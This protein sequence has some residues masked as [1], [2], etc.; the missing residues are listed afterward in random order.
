MRHQLL[1]L[2]DGLMIHSIHFSLI[3]ST[4]FHSVHFCP[5]NPFWT[6]W[7][8]MLIL[9]VGCLFSFGINIFFFLLIFGLKS[10]EFYS[11]RA[12]S[13]VLGKMIQIKQVLE[14]R[15]M[16]PK[17]AIKNKK[18]KYSK[19]YHKI[20]ISKI[21]VLYLYLERKKKKNYNSKLT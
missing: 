18:D 20:Q 11:I 7:A 2:I 3:W 16:G 9:F 10:I 6:N 19:D 14:I 17:K 15:D 12:N 13:L 1:Y 5:F 21:Q 4:S 8:L